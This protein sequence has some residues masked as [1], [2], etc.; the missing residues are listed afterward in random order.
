MKHV[1]EIR[2][3]TMSGLVAGLIYSLLTDDLSKPAPIL[4]GICIGIL[5]GFLAGVFELIVFRPKKSRPAFLLTVLFKVITYFIILGLVIILVK[6]RID[7]LFL[8]EDFQEYIKGKEFREFIF[9]GEFKRILTYSLF[10]IFVII[11]TMQTSRYLGRGVLY[12]M[13]TGKYSEPKEERRIFLLIDICGST[14]IA[15]KIDQIDYFRLLDRFFFDVAEGLRGTNAAIYR[16]IGDQVTITWKAGSKTRNADCIRAF[17]AIKHQVHRQREYYQDHF[18]FVPDFRG[19]AH[20][21]NVV[22]VEIGDVKTQVAF[23]GITLVE[24]NKLEKTEGRI[25]NGL[26]ISED[27]LNELELPVFCTTEVLGECS[28]PGDRIITVYE[29]LES[30]HDQ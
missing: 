15:E 8:P 4:N 9:E 27:L 22:S 30:D 3:I 14:K 28:I 10:A 13:I 7:S 18:T 11:F 26:C 17:Y 24:V 29:V 12:N 5:G 23:Q 2:N 19:T 1:R 6:A 20:I 25:N 16:Y 21:G